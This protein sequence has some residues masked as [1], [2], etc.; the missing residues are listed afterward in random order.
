LL[1]SQLANATELDKQL[2]LDAKHFLTAY[3]NDTN[4]RNIDLLM[5]YSDA[6]TIKV[7][8]ITLDR[9]TKETTFNG[10][11]WK[12][13]LRESWYSGQPAVEPIELHNVSIQD[14][15]TSLEVSAQR[16]SQIRCYWDNNYKVTFAKNETS[17]YQ[18]INETLYIDHKNQC[19]EPDSLIINQDIKINQIQ[20][21]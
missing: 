14:N 21:P 5:L 8:V 7:T 17:E 18:I 20:Q 16:Y 19:Q 1:G 15:G 9:A 6:A 11:A 12:R 3:L 13:L 2:V 10:Q 4:T